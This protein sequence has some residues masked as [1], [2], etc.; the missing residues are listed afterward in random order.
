MGRLLSSASTIVAT[1]IVITT[2]PANS[3]FGTII[4]CTT[5]SDGHDDRLMVGCRTEGA[6]SICTCR[7]TTSN[8]SLEIAVSI[9]T[10][11]DTLEEL[12]HTG[13]GCLIGVQGIEL[14]NRNM[15]VSNN[16]PAL[17]LLW[18]GIVGVRRVSKAS[19]D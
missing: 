12:K 19:S 3:K 10:V 1:V 6:K 18:G 5:L 13:V 15:G 2:I 4:L 8:D 14:L 9:T 11:I 17:E 7:K 16:F